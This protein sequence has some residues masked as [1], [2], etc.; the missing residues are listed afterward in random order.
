MQQERQ[1][2]RRL[3]KPDG[4]GSFE[5]VL[6]SCT[7]VLPDIAFEHHRHLDS[8]RGKARVSQ[9]RRAVETQGTGSVLPPLPDVDDGV[10]RELQPVVEELLRIAGRT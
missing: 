4:V 10:F 7:A 2:R 1:F 3:F 6:L 9:P 8:P 5:Q